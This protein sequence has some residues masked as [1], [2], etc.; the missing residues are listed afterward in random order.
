MAG[1]SVAATAAE[2]RPWKPFLKAIT[3][4]LPVWNEASFKAFSFASAPEFHKN[5]W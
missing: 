1:L 3:S 2:V 4:L 5:K